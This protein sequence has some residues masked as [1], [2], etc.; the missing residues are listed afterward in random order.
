VQIAELK[1]NTIR[2]LKYV[3]DVNV[4]NRAAAASYFGMLSSIPLLAVI[5]TVS[6]Q[7][8][9]DMHS[10]N[11]VGLGDV[12]THE[13][14]IA[15]ARILPLEAK[16]II[17][18]EIIRLQS[19]PPVGL[20][21]LGLLLSLWTAS[22]AYVAVMSAMN[23][24]YGVRD[25]RPIWKVRFNALLMPLLF[26]LILSIAVLSIV[27]VPWAIHALDLDKFS[28][29]VMTVAQWGCLYL[30]IVLSFD[31]TYRVGPC[32]SL[33]SRKLSTGSIVGATIFLFAS[34]L[35]Q[36]YTHQFGS[37]DRVYGSLGGAIIFLVWLWLMNLS[38]LIGCAVN[39]VFEEDCMTKTP[40][41][42]RDMINAH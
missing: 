30:I 22:S 16:N 41:K 39:K 20:L 33:K 31:A 7:L 15:L 25:V 19:Q 24:I 10:A 27:A 14:N 1:Q 28:G 38:L 6:A 4:A 21:S 37:Y 17:T 12:T 13:L 3:R 9:P 36:L 11:A 2:V 34:L 32:G 42:T 35:F 5:L 29:L 23:E 40:G 18:N 8:L 26:T